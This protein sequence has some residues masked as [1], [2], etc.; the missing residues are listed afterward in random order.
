LDVIVEDFVAVLVDEDVA[1]A[2]EIME[3]EVVEAT[4]K[5]GIDPHDQAWTSH[6]GWQDQVS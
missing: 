2:V 6:Q 5:E 3:A 1:K 4:A